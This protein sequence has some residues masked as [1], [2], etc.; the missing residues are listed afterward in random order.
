LHVHYWRHVLVAR[1][2]LAH[3]Y[4]LYAITEKTY[5]PSYNRRPP[6]LPKSDRYCVMRYHIP[7]DS[8]IFFPAAHRLSQPSR[9]THPCHSCP[10]TRHSCLSRRRTRRR[11]RVPKQSQDW[12]ERI[13]RRWARC[14]KFENARIEKRREASGPLIATVSAANGAKSGPLSLK[15][16]IR[17]AR[18]VRRSCSK[19]CRTVGPRLCII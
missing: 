19:L 14:Y 17:F 8:R 15:D 2:S 1:T 3:Q 16:A 12:T 4:L 18:V 5:H 11:L 13:Y 7:L 10:Y 6:F 9:G